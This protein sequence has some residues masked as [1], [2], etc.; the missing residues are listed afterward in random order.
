MIYPLL[1]SLLIPILGWSQNLVSVKGTMVPNSGSFTAKSEK[2]KG[3]LLKQSDHSF[4]ADRLS[5]FVDSFQSENKLRDKHF[6]QYLAGDKKPPQR[7]I[8]LLDLTAR[9][10]K[11]T[12]S[13]KINGVTKPIEISYQEKDHFIE[14]SFEVKASDFNLL[15]ASYLGIGLEDLVKINVQY[16]YEKK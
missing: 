5:V 10:G 11:G 2:L 8:D 4:T 14:A 3:R 16:T 6:A 15:P 13:L 9:D 1:F 12:A 7:R